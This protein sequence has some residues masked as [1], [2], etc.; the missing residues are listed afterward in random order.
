MAIVYN[1]CYGGYGLSPAAAVEVFRRKGKEV[2]PTKWGGVEEVETGKTLYVTSLPRHDPDLVAVVREMGDEANGEC[3][4]LL[5]HECPAGSI[6]RVKQ[7]D[8]YEE[9]LFQDTED[10]NITVD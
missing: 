5:I 8:G 6:Y 4:R 7:Y 2:K 10:W 1:G 9:L 3:A